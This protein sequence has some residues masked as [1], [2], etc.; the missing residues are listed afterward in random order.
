M[1]D[2]KIYVS[3]QNLFFPCAFFKYN[4]RLRTGRRFMQYLEGLPWAA[5]VGEILPWGQR[6]PLFQCV[7]EV[8]PLG[9]EL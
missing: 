9:I 5:P 6:S 1:Q 3:V 4:D 8:L 2:V 7:P